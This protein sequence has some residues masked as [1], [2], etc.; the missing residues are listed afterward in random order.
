MTPAAFLKRRAPDWQELESLLQRM[1]RRMDRQASWSEMTRFAR[2]YRAV[3]TDLSLAGA[4]RVPRAVQ[5]QLEDL[6]SRSH[7]HLY[8]S[9]K[10]K[11]VDLVRYFFRTVPS[12][13]YHDVYV[14]ICLLV[15][16]VPF[17]L[18]GFLAYRS[19]D[20]ARS[21]LGPAVMEQYQEMHESPREEST[22]GG[23]V[24]ATGFYV[25][26]NVSID[27]LVFGLGILG[28][29]GSL[30]F[31]LFNAVHLGAVLGFL[32]TTPAR[33]QILSWIPAHA[34]FE[35]TA[36]G[37]AAG[38]GLRIGFAMISSGGRTRLRALREEARN[39]VPII[40]AASA[41]T[42]FAAGIEA[43]V[44]PSPLPIVWKAALGGAC[45]VLMLVY[46]VVLGREKEGPA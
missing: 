33:D 29:V 36:I 26:N 25:A 19:T 23:V 11:A 35:L 21:V 14:R 18:C 22:A 16:Y 43:L 37:I 32:M 34:P 30:L 13:V 24:A 41:L 5:G 1:D 10:R 31:T 40:G 6:V 46:F 45:T 15:F 2:L 20:F 4:Y 42:F 44:A 8:A 27:M 12:V 9:R 28:G 38:A 3:C 7:N 17:F 39:A